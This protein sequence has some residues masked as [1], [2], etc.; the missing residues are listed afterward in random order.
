V[1]GFVTTLVRDVPLGT[2]PIVYLDRLRSIEAGGIPYIDPVF[3]HLPGMLVPMYAARLIAWTGADGSYVLAFGA[4]MAICLW[5]S[6]RLVVGLSAQPRSTAVRWL[7][8]LA[9][10]VPLVAF[11]NDPW[12]VMWALAALTPTL[13]PVV[14]GVASFVAVLSKG[15]PVVTAVAFWKRGHRWLAASTFLAGV[16]AIGLMSAPG[17]Q[18]L[19]GGVGLHSESIGGSLVGLWRSIN[20]QDLRLVLTTA[21]YI[22]VPEPLRLVGPALAAVV[23]TIGLLAMRRAR[24]KQLHLTATGIL[25]IAVILASRLFSAQ[26]V[27]WLVPFVALS[28]RRSSLVLALVINLQAVYTVYDFFAIYDA[29]ILWWGGAL[30]RNL[31]LLGLAGTL[32]AE[33][34]SDAGEMDD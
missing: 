8:S 22:E 21:A 10:L 27:L 20:G 31:L 15:W 17:F 18:E 6:G 33:C 11:R 14:R 16:A 12:V 2:D 4:L 9:P 26:Y 5:V 13:S 3:E 19:Q 1:V 29:S 24:S 34:W 25:V 30:F 28:R 7:V 23:G 32:A